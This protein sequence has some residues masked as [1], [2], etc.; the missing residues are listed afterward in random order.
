MARGNPKQWVDGWT[1]STNLLAVRAE[2]VCKVF[3]VVPRGM[4]KDAIYVHHFT[5]VSIFIGR[6]SMQREVS[7]HGIQW[8]SKSD[9]AAAELVTFR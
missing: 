5:G 2:G 7:I 4:L 1:E 8:N 3:I 6:K 9:Q